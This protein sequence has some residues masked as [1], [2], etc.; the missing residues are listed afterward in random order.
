[1]RI[2]FFATYPTQPNGYAR[3]ANILSNQLAE[4]GHEVHYLG[5]S[6]FKTSSIA[7]TIHPNIRLIDALEERSSTST[8]LYG[9]DVICPLIERIQPEL[10]FLYNDLVVICRI[11]NEFIE[12]KVNNKTF[13]V[14]TY[15]DLVYDYEKHVMI[16]HMNLFS[17]Y[18]LVFSKCWKDNL[19][20][21]GVPEYKIDIL[22]HGMDTELFLQKS[23]QEVV[24]IRA[25]FNFSANDFIV[26]NTN[27]NNYRKAIDITLEAFIHFLGRNNCDPRIKLYLNMDTTTPTGYDIL[28]LIKINC[29]RY[30]LDFE[31][32]TCRHIFTRKQ[33]A[34]LSDQSINEVYNMCDVGV[35]TC[36]GEGFG[37]CNLEHGGIG[38]PQVVSRVGALNDIFTEDIATLIEPQA[39][40]Y[41]HDAIDVHGGYI[42]ICSPVDFSDALDKYY[43]NRVLAKNH[44]EMA[45]KHLIEN[46]AWTHVLTIF[47]QKVNLMEHFNTII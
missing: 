18:I 36:I 22:P 19:I 7:R 28:N 20:Q 2:L 6:N 8:E 9:V 46:Y 1:M 33:D 38:K 43:H 23:E 26:L 34:Y 3:I 37:L 11:F 31:K 16:Q 15:L 35:N 45:R 42:H 21:M 41:I 4:M 32:I 29:L 10:L 12:R 27:R 40:L 17:D 13:K 24:D 25:Q 5:I 44:G 14:C 47:R 30:N 39:K